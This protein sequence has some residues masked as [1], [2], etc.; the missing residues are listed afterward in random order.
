LAK[1][2]LFFTYLS[3][4][5]TE[6]FWT[7][8]NVDGI[9]MPDVPIYVLT[10]NYT[11]SGA[12]EFA[13]DL[14]NQKRAVIVGEVTGGGANPGQMMSV[15]SSFIAF[16]PNGRAINPVTKTNWEGTGVTP[17]IEIAAPKA[18][19]EAQILALQKISESTKDEKEK[20][21]YQWLTESVQGVMNA[22]ILDEASLKSYAGTYGPRTI[23]YE[24]GSL[25]YKRGSGPEFMLTYMSDDTFMFNDIEY[26]R[27]KFERDSAG[28][29]TGITGIYDDGHTDS[30]PKTN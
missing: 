29:I 30:S 13:Y 10:S 21:H 7:L 11:F 1:R 15:N 6:E 17:D 24:E 28:N 25:Y 23:I 5:F 4:N 8:R 22:R 2:A 18:L 19:Y 12:E 3:F 16:I 26:F 20:K 14:Q 9:K 27:I